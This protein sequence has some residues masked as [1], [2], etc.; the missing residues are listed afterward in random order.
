M[1]SPKTTLIARLSRPTRLDRFLR[2]QFPHAGRQAVQRLISGGKVRLNGQF[3]RLS[4]WEVVTGD[5][6]ELA[7]A[8]LAKTPGPAAFDDAWVV[9]EE[10]ELIVVNKPSGLLSQ[11][12][13]FATAA[14]LLDL[15][16]QRFGEVVLFHRLDRDTSG[17]LL[18][19]RPGAINKYLDEAFKG[20]GVQK[21][22]VAVVRSK[23]RRGSNRL[24][25]SGMID[26]HLGPHPKRRD[27][28]AIVRSGGRRAI[29]RFAVEAE[30]QGRQLVRLWPETGRTHQLRVHL[31]SLDAP[32]IG[33]RLYGPPPQA[34]E[35]LMLHAQRIHLPASGNFPARVY[36]AP[37][38]AGFWPPKEA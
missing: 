12:T 15:A 9:A 10:P 21:E 19:S 26:N 24:Q 13:R 11:A 34:E 23:T 25:Q 22:Y 33:D 17:L 31:A 2:D 5:R 20:H 8:P 1:A 36:E 30:A 38:P 3:V 16:R 14:N 29:T 28:M 7:E 32:I 27:Q 37:M 18:L 4:S 6:I 35:R